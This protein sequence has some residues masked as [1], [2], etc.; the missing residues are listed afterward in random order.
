[1]GRFRTSEHDRP[2]D[3]V[4]E[5]VTD[6]GQTIRLTGAHDVAEYAIG[7]EQAQNAFV[8]QMFHHVVKQPLL[9][10]GADTLGQLRQRFAASNFN[11]QKLLV[12]I[13]TVSAVHGL[14]KQVAGKGHSS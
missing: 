11:M 6:D 1:V 12:E 7:S 4:S 14:G 8:E 3:A 10:Y 9:A 2:I 5:Y 13:A